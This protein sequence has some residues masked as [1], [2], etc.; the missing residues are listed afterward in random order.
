M[1]YIGLCVTYNLDL[2]SD[3]FS[4]YYYHDSYDYDSYDYYYS[5]YLFCT[6]LHTFHHCLHSLFCVSREPL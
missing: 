6:I 1:L 4:F 2:D 3:S 5:H